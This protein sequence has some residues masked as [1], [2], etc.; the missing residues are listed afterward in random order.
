MP[1]F[2]HRPGVSCKACFSED[3]L[4]RYLLEITADSTGK[5]LCVIMQ[6]PSD[7]DEHVSDKSIQFLETLFFEKC[8][9]ETGP[10]GIITVVN[11]YALVQKHDFHGGEKAVGPLNDPIIQKAISTAD[12]VLLAWGRSKNYMERKNMIWA[13]LDKFPSKPLFKSE[14]HPSR[15]SYSH[16][17]IPIS[18]R[19]FP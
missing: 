9:P 12:I 15:A 1:V 13:M 8:P 4:F 2:R 16:F 10:I 6:N 5:K 3:R 7:A 17:L 18:T 19:S 14:R 11:L